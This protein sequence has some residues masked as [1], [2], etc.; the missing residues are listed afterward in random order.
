MALTYLDLTNELIREFNE[1]ELDSTTFSS[2]RGFQARAKDCIN[3]ALRKINSAAWH[4]PFLAIEHTQTLTAGTYEYAWPSTFKNVEWNSFQIQKNES[5]NAEFT[6]LEPIERDEWYQKYKDES[7]RGIANADYR[8]FPKFVFPTHG[9]GFGL[10]SNPD[11]AYSLKYR[12]YK[13]LVALSAYNDET[14]VPDQFKHVILLGAAAHMY[15]FIDGL[16][17]SRSMDQSEFQPALR[18]MRSLLINDDQY[19]RDYRVKW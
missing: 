2:A 15:R 17:F 11:Q 3:V 9:F 19:I 5:L 4:W 16:E 13:N 6:I 12:Y 8:G 18:E 14:L 1:V 10:Y 7:D